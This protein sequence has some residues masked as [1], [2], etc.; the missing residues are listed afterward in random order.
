VTGGISGVVS[1]GGGMVSGNLFGVMFLERVV[2]F[3]TSG[4]GWF[5]MNSELVTS[6]NGTVSMFVLF[7]RVEG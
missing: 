1:V 7:M 3:R 5:W 4:F 2:G 6:V